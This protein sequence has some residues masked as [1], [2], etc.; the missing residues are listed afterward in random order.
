LRGFAWWAFA[1]FL[2]NVS[3][4]PAASA[5]P[6]AALQFTAGAPQQAA[7]LAAFLGAT[8]PWL[9]DV[10]AWPAAAEKA[11]LAVAIYHEARGETKSGQVAVARVILNRSRSRAYPAS[12]CG[13]VFQ[14]AHKRN[15][16]QFSFACDDLPDV[17][18]HPRSWETS[19]QIAVGMLCTENCAMPIQNPPGA[20]ASLRFHQATHYHAV[21][22]APS[23][24]KKLRLLGR[25]GDHLFF[26]SDRVLRKSL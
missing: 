2:L 4:A 23:W 12:I 6:A 17:P 13:V 14:N 19:L 11:C 5:L 16:C 20:T 10:G 7:A 18:G 24:S 3:V 1:F 8:R 9:P 26:A 25:I 22:V 21:Y 15:R